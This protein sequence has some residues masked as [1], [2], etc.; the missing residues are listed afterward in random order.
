MKMD[1]KTFQHTKTYRVL[2]KN[3]SL[4][5]GIGIFF[6]I[7]WMYGMI[8]QDDVSTLLGAFFGLIML[9]FSIYEYQRILQVKRI[10]KSFKMFRGRIVNV[11]AP[12][13]YKWPVNLIV[14]FTDQQKEVKRLM[15]HAIIYINH[16]NDYL[17][18]QVNV[19]YSEQFLYVLFDDPEDLIHS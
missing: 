2:K 11:H 17:E 7:L 6:I 16:L 18:K 9:G 15:T 5:S 19:Y 4:Y 14:E 10:L 3:L 12:F 13:N 1:L 8:T